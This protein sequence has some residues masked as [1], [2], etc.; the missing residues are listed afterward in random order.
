VA[1]LDEL[2]GAPIA[3]QRVRTSLLSLVALFLAALGLYGVL[4][5]SVVRRS[6]KLASAWRSGRPRRSYTA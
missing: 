6:P 2:V 1:T 5:Y 4:A 3:A